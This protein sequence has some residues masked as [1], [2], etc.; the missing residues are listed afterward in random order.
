MKVGLTNI[1]AVG[2]VEV[3][4]TYIKSVAVLEVSCSE[5]PEKLGDIVVRYTVTE[6]VI[7]SS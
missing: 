5:F 6:L 1:V 2:G 3:S 7:I 4:S